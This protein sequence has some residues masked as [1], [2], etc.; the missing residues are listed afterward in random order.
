M[1][2]PG[3]QTLSHYLQIALSLSLSIQLHHFPTLRY[4]PVC[5]LPFFP[6]PNLAS[7]MWSGKMALRST[8]FIV[9]TVPHP[10]GTETL[11]LSG[12]IPVPSENSDWPWLGHMPPP[13]P[14]SRPRKLETSNW[15]AWGRAEPWL[16][17]ARGD[18][19]KRKLS[20]CYRKKRQ[21]MLVRQK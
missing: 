11:P 8:E 16:E 14:V 21:G 3:A 6:T 20:G 4:I 19:T 15:S 7:S 1:L 18:F 13:G 17:Q 12:S 5:T 10:K 2:D 9:F